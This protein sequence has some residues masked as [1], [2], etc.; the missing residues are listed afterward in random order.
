MRIALLSSVALVPACYSTKP[1]D[2]QGSDWN[3]TVVVYRGSSLDLGAMAAYIGIDDAMIAKLHN[4]D[5]LEIQLPPGQHRLRA[6]ANQYRQRA[7]VSLDV[8]DFDKL[9]FEARPNPML[10]TVSTPIDA[11]AVSAAYE[12]L[13]HVP[14]VLEPRTADDF[15]AIGP[16]LKRVEVERH[17]AN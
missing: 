16:N 14:F 4:N 17:V 11:G 9:F 10:V 7:L 1:Y 2:Y 12:A 3:A 8:A 13:E 15:R 5:Y 6:A